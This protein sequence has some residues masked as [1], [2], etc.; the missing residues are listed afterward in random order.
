METIGSF[1]LVNLIYLAN[2]PQQ[3]IKNPSSVY[4]MHVPCR[5]INTILLFIF[6][7]FFFEINTLL[8]WEK[9]YWKR[10]SLN[11]IFQDKKRKKKRKLFILISK[12]FSIIIL[13]H[14]YNL[15]QKS[16]LVRKYINT[17]KKKKQN[18]WLAN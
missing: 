14:S 2:H 6:P 12:C 16:K 15:F 5:Y 13:F 7:Y 10:A 4:F 18:E 17:N 9:N 11:L 8:L 1:K 3:N